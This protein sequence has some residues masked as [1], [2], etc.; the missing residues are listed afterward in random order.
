[1]IFFFQFSWI[2]IH[3]TLVEKFFNLF[4]FLIPK[5]SLFFINMVRNISEEAIKDLHS[6]PHN[7]FPFLIREANMMSS[8]L[9]PN[10]Y[11]K[12]GRIL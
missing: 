8:G 11:G 3:I 1:M 6:F 9:W 5:T 7:Y 12:V 10:I 4:F 2:K